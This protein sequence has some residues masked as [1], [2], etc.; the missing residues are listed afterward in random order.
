MPFCWFVI[1]NQTWT[2]T[3]TGIDQTRTSAEVRMIR[4]QVETR[5]RRSAISEPSTIVSMTFA[6]V[7]ITVRSSV[8][9]KTVSPRTER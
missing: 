1:Q 7:K 6:I 4:T 3:T 5:T 8:C 2:A 9:Q